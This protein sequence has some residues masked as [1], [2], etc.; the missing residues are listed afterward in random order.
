[1]S[2]NTQSAI[3]T[4]VSVATKQ[5]RPDS[6]PER[7]PIT[8][9]DGTVTIY[10]EERASYQSI[11]GV[12][13]AGK[14][15]LVTNGPVIWEIVWNRALDNFDT[16]AKRD[17]AAAVN[18]AVGITYA[19][20][21]VTIYV[22]YHEKKWYTCTNRKI[23]AFKSFWANENL[24]FG[25]TFA[26]KL[27]L[28]YDHPLK[29][30]DDV[31]PAKASD[32]YDSVLDKN[33]RYVF[34]SPF[35]YSERIGSKGK[36]QTPILIKSLTLDGH[37]APLTNARLAPKNVEYER[38]SD[39]FNA[40]RDIDPDYHQ[41]VI[42]TTPKGDVKIINGEYQRR[43]DLRGNSPS[44]RARYLAIRRTPLA[45]PFLALYPEVDADAIEVAISDLTQKLVMMGRDR[46]YYDMKVDRRY[47]SILDIVEWLFGACTY[48]NIGRVLAKEPVLLNKALRYSTYENA[49][50]RA[51][52]DAKKENDDNKAAEAA[53][54]ATIQIEPID[55]S[56]D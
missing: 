20:E 42:I 26:K 14:D 52:S 4:S 36:L 33:V 49:K 32:L 1:M 54:A 27:A 56:L 9:N 10:C 25:S 53:E 29:D 12:I 38:P 7:V 6:V 2:G 22:F 46:L 16:P 30:D 44:L 3:T 37:E 24:K 47:A 18:D 55:H 19:V 15:V 23:D 28:A 17:L 41:G 48:S 5:P 13:A 8:D 31:T 11:R 40:V 51:M 43:C 50:M 39:V 34:I 35:S 21:G 45:R